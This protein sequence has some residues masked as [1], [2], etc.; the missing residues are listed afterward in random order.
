MKIEHQVNWRDKGVLLD[1]RGHSEAASAGALA[2]SAASA[3]SDIAGS[4]IEA[5]VTMLRPEGSRCTAASADGAGELS[6][7][8]QRTGLGPVARAL[9]GAMSL[10][11]NDHCFDPRWP[12][13][14]GSLRAA[15]FRSAISVPLPLNRGYRAALTF[16]SAEINVFAPAVAT[17]TLTF[18]DVAA[19]S[20]QVA[21][22]VR[23][24]LAYSAGLRASMASRTSINT[25][26]GVIME[27]NQCSFEEAC[28]VLLETAALRNLPVR[29]VAEGILLDL[30]GGIP[31]THFQ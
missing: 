18:S 28:Q 13:Y 11:L 6:R 8:D 30:P 24:D 12:E 25:A 5:T 4:F 10:I 27:Q 15:G 14:L 17:Q 3:V 9:G 29:N 19:R 22:K 20:L 26:C 16:Y 1:I 2:R 23:A 7:W 31:A 21:L